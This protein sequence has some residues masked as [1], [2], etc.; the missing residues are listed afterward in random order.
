L[1]VNLADWLSRQLRPTYRVAIKKR[2]YQTDVDDFLLVGLPRSVLSPKSSTPSSQLPRYY[3]AGTLASTKDRA[4]AV[5]MPM[6]TT[7]KEGYERNST[8]NNRGSG[9]GY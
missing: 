5:T 4:I 9:Y 7:I 3:T 1:I 8:G 6:P 2:T